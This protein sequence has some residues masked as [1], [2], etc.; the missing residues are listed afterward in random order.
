M[1]TLTVL[2]SSDYFCI[3]TVR[4]VDSELF[5][6]T[7]YHVRSALLVNTNVSFNLLIYNAIDTAI[8]FAS[9]VFDSIHSLYPNDIICG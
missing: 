6:M 2:K 8:C 1:I 3:D 9:V 4:P 7:I 5:A